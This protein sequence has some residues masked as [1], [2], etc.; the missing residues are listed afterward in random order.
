MH[1]NSEGIITDCNEKLADMLGV[2][3]EQITSFNLLVS[4]KNE[5]MKEAV[6]QALSGK[7]GAFEGEYTSVSGGRPFYA[8]VTYTPLFGSGHERLGGIAIVDD[9]TELKEAEKLLQASKEKYRRIVE[10]ANEGIW[11]VDDTQTTTFINVKMAEMI[12][13]AVDEI[14]GKNFE[15][16]L[17]TEDLIDHREKM[18]HRRQGKPDDYNQRLCR[19]DG[20]ELWT[21]VSATPILESEGTFQGAFKMFSDMTQERALQLQLFQSQKMEALGILV[22]GIAHDFNNMLQII[23]GYGELLMGDIEQAKGETRLLTTILKTAQTASEQVTKFMELGQQSMVFPKPTDLNARIRELEPVI[24][25]L[26]NIAHLEIDLIAEPTIIKQDPGQLG[27]IIMI[28]ATNASE[29]MPNGGKLELSTTKVMLD[30]AFSKTH[31]QGAKAGPHVLLTVTDTGKGIDEAIL[32]MIFDPFFSTKERGNIKGMG[33]GLS[34]LRGI[35]QQRGGFV[36]CKSDLDRG[37][38]F[39]LYF[40]E[41]EPP[42]T[43]VSED[44][45][46]SQIEFEKGILVVED[47]SLVGVLERTAL[48]AAGYQTIPASNGKDAVNVYKERHSEIGLVILDILMPEMNG[49]DCLMELRKINP[50]VKVIVFTGYDP[51][52]ELYLA[53]KPYVISFLHKPCKMSQL[54][55]VVQLVME[56]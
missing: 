36:T 33:L 51:K 13:Y 25:K 10:T 26:P 31:Y 48:D 6:R 42:T 37:S 2:S 24:S 4:L 29:A 14:I 11:V 49:R 45:T 3:R 46:I 7:V 15:S 44:T 22:G 21:R 28:L 19:K 16:F 1:F 30:E 23:I 5:S 41:I 8:K 43:P 35:V 54:V 9:Y 27:Q 38:T 17:F 47:S 53:M 12:G 39:R 20:S 50:L 56:G 18:E 34:V 40:P 55:E 32:P 52:G